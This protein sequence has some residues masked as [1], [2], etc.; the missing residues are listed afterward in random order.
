M[1]QSGHLDPNQQADIFN[2]VGA[3]QNQLAPGTLNKAAA[4]AAFGDIQIKEL[5]PKGE[6]IGIWELK[7]PFLTNVKFGDLDYASED[8]LNLEMTFRY[9][10]ALYNGAA[11][12]VSDDAGND[13]TSATTQAP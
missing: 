5:G 12:V 7:N 13:T 9:D 8:L 2:G 4:K 1:Y 3:S 6:N 11:Q 10:F